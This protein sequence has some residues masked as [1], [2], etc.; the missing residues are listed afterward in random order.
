MLTL[1]VNQAHYQVLCV[2]Y[3]GSAAARKYLGQEPL[4]NVRSLWSGLCILTN[5]LR[6]HMPFSL[7]TKDLS[8]FNLWYVFWRRSAKGDGPCG[9][10]AMSS[11]ELAEMTFES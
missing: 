5:R 8:L 4:V 3:R 7:I 10:G 2:A 1:P 11:L 9:T 6:I